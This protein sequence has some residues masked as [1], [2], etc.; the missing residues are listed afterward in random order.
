VVVPPP[1]LRAEVGDE[2]AVELVGV[3]DGVQAVLGDLPDLLVGVEPL[4]LLL[5]ALADHAHDGVDVHVAGLDLEAHAAL[6][7]AGARAA[8]WRCR[9]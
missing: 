8:P 2:I 3:E 9:G 5:D 4:L 6:S 7:A 1:L